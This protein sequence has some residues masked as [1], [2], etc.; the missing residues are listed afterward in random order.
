MISLMLS[1]HELRTAEDHVRRYCGLPWSGG[2]PEVWAYQYYDAVPQGNPDDVA[3]TDVLAAAALHPKLT[4]FDLV[5]FVEH[6]R[7]LQ[8]FLYSAPKSDLADID[9]TV[10]DELPKIAHR[11]VELS[12]LTKV[13]HRKRPGL[14]PLLDRSVLD[15]YRAELTTRRADAWPE[16]VRSLARD[17]ALNRERL[18]QLRRLVPLTDLRITDI[19]MWM[20]YGK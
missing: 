6:R 17:L 18:E 7:D 2:S 12:L 19:A 15:W 8:S 5:W 14:I 13:L 4:R 11:G 1:G 9:P 10:L 3:P 20:E 16:L